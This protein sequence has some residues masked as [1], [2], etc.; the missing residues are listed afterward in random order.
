MCGETII[1]VFVRHGNVFHDAN[2][3]GKRAGA[4]FNFRASV[5]GYSNACPINAVLLTMTAG[6][7]ETYNDK[8]GTAIFRP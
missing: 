6:E 1:P 3:P 2:H 7:S 4:F 8:A 5:A